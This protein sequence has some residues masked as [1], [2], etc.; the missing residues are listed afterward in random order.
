[1]NQNF[2]FKFLIFGLF[3]TN[4]FSIVSQTNEKDLNNS[5]KVSLLLDSASNLLGRNPNLALKIANECKLNAKEN[6]YNLAK[7]Y[8]LIGAGN[9]YLG[10]YRESEEGYL[11]ALNYDILNN[12]TLNT[13]KDYRGIA[14]VNGEI[15]NFEKSNKNLETALDLANKIK[16]YKEVIVINECLGIFNFYQKKYLNAVTHYEV[17]LSLSNE[18]K[19]SSSL[20]S[21]YYNLASVYVEISNEELALKYLLKGRE[22]VSTQN[23]KY[24]EGSIYTSIGGIYTKMNKNDLAVLNYEKAIELY[25]DCSY[26]KG[27]A[28][29]SISLAII[30]EELGEMNRSNN[31]AR[32]AFEYAKSIDDNVV[33]SL[34]YNL[35]SKNYLLKKEYQKSVK[36][37]TSALKHA[38]KSK[39]LLREKDAL[40]LLYKGF[41]KLKNTEKAFN[42]YKNYVLLK[43][44]LEGL[45]MI[46]KIENIEMK[47]S[48]D[49]LEKETEIKTQKLKLIKE[50]GRLEKSR[51]YISII[52]VGFIFLFIIGIFIFRI[53]KVKKE[54]EITE[55]NKILTDVKNKLALL[56]LAQEK[57]NKITLEKEVQLKNNRIKQ[58]A[59]I[60][61]QK[62]EL[63]DEFSNE[64]IFNENQNLKKRFNKLIDSEEER[65]F[66]NQEIQQ[67]D[68]KFYQKLKAKFDNLSDN[69]LKLSSMLKMGL[70]SKEMATLLSI[71]SSSVD[72][73]RSRLRKKMNIPKDDN[74]ID[75]I[76]SI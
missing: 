46:A 13:I 18:T 58:L 48:I 16:D 32:E 24:V 38:I 20:F 52:L 34:Y 56:S 42:Y 12:D 39:D 53:S 26:T 70:S 50:E 44:S 5:D 51:I 27:L 59:N 9:L 71:S 66:F 43:D 57:E 63:L 37:S 28:Y 62:N 23:N 19:D 7:S 45:E 60:I 68:A 76:K 15:S 36:N 25:L 22:L 41:E 30:Y 10:K 35:I 69:D 29:A 2:I 6:P 73:A 40:E 1:M 67:I 11:K 54:K 74:L 21:I 55:K 33:L 3:L 64:N 75:F 4:T 47:R 61:N 14:I 65:N 49:I 31:Y 8:R 72:V 17:A